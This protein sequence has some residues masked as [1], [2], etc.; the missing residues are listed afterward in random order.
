MLSMLGR[1]GPVGGNGVCRAPHVSVG[2][3]KRNREDST[4]K[5]GPSPNPGPDPAVCSRAQRIK[6]KW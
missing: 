4:A 6:A 3:D 1:A 5:P 2:G